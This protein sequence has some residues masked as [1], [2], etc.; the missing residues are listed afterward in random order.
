MERTET[1]YLIAVAVLAVI[2]GIVA[3]VDITTSIKQ[4]RQEAEARKKRHNMIERSRDKGK[5][6][7]DKPKEG[8]E[9]E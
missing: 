9:R 8:R 3:I 2:A 5:K 7:T 4:Y 1:Y 6:E